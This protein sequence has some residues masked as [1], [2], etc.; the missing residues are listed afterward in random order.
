MKYNKP[1]FIKILSII[2]Y[3]FLSFTIVLEILSRKSML[4]NRDLIY[5]NQF[6]QKN[7]FTDSILKICFSIVLLSLVIVAINLIR[8]YKSLFKRPLIYISLKILFINIILMNML[9]FYKNSTMIAFS[10]IL[11]AVGFILL[12]KYIEY[13]Y[14]K[15]VNLK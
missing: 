4:V 5:R 7:I 12:V 6:I 1:I 14:I 2:S 9:I 11:M 13:V 10:F 15:I 8:N 3:I